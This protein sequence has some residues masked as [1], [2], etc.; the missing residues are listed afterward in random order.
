MSS[1]SRTV[2]TEI[3][4]GCQVGDDVVERSSF[5]HLP[6][7]LYARDWLYTLLPNV[8]PLVKQHTVM[9]MAMLACHDHGDD[10]GSDMVMVVMDA[11]LWILL[12]WFWGFFDLLPQPVPQVVIRVVTFHQM[13][14][15]SNQITDMGTQQQQ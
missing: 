5:Q 2:H 3:L 14:H 15:C 13:R 7:V 8:L 6:C 12:V 9:M 11:I 4:I 1:A 10:H